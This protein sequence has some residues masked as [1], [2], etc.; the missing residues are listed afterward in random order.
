MDGRSRWGL[1]RSPVH[2][3]IG[4][5]EEQQSRNGHSCDNRRD[6]TGFRKALP[7]AVNASAKAMFRWDHA[8]RA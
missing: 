4:V 1:R 7:I 8:A 6:A 5:V 2:D 3:E